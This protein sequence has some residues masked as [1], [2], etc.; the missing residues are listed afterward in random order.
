MYKAV[1]VIDVR[2]LVCSFL[3]PAQGT[4]SECG[5]SLRSKEKLPYHLCN[6]KM[7]SYAVDAAI[8]DCSGPADLRRSAL[9]NSLPKRS[10]TSLTLSQF[11]LFAEFIRS[12]A[13][14]SASKV[15]AAIDSKLYPLCKRL[16]EQRIQRSTAQNT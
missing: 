11:W 8:V 15:A 4:V 2:I 10:D 14:A 1:I 7:E 13:M 6:K 16:Q 9:V 3:T 5:K 12:R